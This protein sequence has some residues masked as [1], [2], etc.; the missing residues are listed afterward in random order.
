MGF[1]SNV[2]LNGVTARSLDSRGVT[3]T[4]AEGLPISA[5]AGTSSQ[6]LPNQCAVVCS[7]LTARA[8][9]TGKGRIYLPLLGLTLQGDG[10]VPSA[11]QTAIA[12]GMKAL[13]DTLNTALVAV[14]T[15][16]K[17]GVQSHTASSQDAG[18]YTGAAVT[19][20]AIGNIVD[21]QRRRRGSLTEVYISAAIT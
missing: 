3:T 19:N 7:L 14:A 1:S 13:I 15:S 5:T 12:N 8:G 6:T 11:G 18:A 16:P 2:T 21:T 17:I 9:R 20:V 4:Q 10:T